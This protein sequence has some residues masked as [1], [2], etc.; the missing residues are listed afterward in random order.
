M[1]RIMFTGFSNAEAICDP[2]ENNFIEAEGIE[3][4]L[5]WL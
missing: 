3:A 2:D 5:W 4:S 1:T